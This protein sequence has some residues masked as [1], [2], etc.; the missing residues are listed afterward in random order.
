[1]KN[2]LIVLGIAIIVIAGAVYFIQKGYKPKT[3][4]NTTGTGTNV[5][6]QNFAFSPSTLTITKGQTV[7][8]TNEDSVAHQIA[9]DTFNS[10]LMSNGQT[11]SFTFDTVGTFNYR[12]SIHPTMTGQIIVQ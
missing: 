6:I 1:M 11:F 7:T 5:T 3:N 12:C 10:N 4:T 9:S 8:W 2:I